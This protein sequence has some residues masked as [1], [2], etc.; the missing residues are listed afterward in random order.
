[1]EEGLIRGVPQNPKT[2]LCGT[3]IEWFWMFGLYARIR[4]VGLGLY[5]GSYLERNSFYKENFWLFCKKKKLKNDYVRQNLMDCRMF[6]FLSKLGL[7][8]FVYNFTK[9]C[10]ILWLLCKVRFHRCYLFFFILMNHSIV[11]HI[12]DVRTF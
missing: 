12:W 7:V 9:V 8:I 4:F 2:P 6:K 3:E 11:W 5:E 1:M 10:Q